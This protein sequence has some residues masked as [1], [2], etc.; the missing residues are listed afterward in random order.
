MSC[1]D[2]PFDE[3]SPL[4]AVSVTNDGLMKM[5]NQDD[6]HQIQRISWGQKCIAR[7][8]GPYGATRN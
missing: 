2:D 3:E 4:D 1:E 6:N 5:V 8:E 7:L